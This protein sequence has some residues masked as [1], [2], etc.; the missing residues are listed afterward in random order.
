[1][2]DWRVIMAL[3]DARAGVRAPRL[4]GLPLCVRS[5]PRSFGRVEGDAGTVVAGG[6]IPGPG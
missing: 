2:D 5:S 4:S 6:P 1:V 3:A